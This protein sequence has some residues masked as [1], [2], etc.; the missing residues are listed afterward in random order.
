Y[1]D[2]MV[3]LMLILDREHADFT[4]KTGWK[5]FGLPNK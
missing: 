5:F 1:L 4:M 3:S 2:G